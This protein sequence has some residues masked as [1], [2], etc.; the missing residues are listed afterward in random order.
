ML[1]LEKGLASCIRKK[2]EQSAKAELY[3]QGYF[4]EKICKHCGTPFVPSAP[5]EHYCSDFCKR[6]EYVNTYYKRNYKIT[7]DEY[8]N[9][10]EKQNFK[11]ALCNKENF[12][13]G[14]RHSGV[15]VVDHDHKTGEI[16]GLLCHN[17]NRALG[18]LH[19]N[20]EII[21]KIRPYLERVTTIPKGSTPKA[22]V[23]GSGTENDIVYS[24]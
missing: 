12:A 17:C 9:M 24:A 18:L 20:L 2:E 4:K 10:A 16:R 3:P 22:N 14:E 13:M 21:D 8:L 15:L 1:L 6:Y 19:D 7:L 23:G 5:C 11:C